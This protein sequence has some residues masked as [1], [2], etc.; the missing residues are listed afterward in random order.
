MG[1][2]LIP[3]G[4][5]ELLATLAAVTKF[6]QDC[7]VYRL[8]NGKLTAAGDYTM[9]AAQA[10]EARTPKEIRLLCA[11]SLCEGGGESCS[12]EFAQSKL[13]EAAQEGLVDAK[14]VAE[15]M[16]R[17]KKEDI[18]HALRKLAFANG[19]SEEEARQFLEE[20]EPCTAAELMEQIEGIELMILFFG[21]PKRD[22]N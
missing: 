19:A 10:L 20:C 1:T 6:S 2:R 3:E 14:D 22:I 5:G 4:G 11:L 16:Q 13:A 7:Y 18:M 17:I 12:D 21:V 9:E 8:R 15:L